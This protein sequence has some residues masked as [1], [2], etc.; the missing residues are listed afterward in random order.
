LKEKSMLKIYGIPNCDTVQKAIKW[1][2]TH[3]MEYEFHDFKKDGIT[4]R[5][6]ESW[7]KKVPVEK[8]M[9]KAST[10][11]KELPTDQKPTTPEAMI[12]LMTSQPTSIKRPVLE[13]G[14]KVLVGFDLAAYEKL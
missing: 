7:L 10:P 11:Y 14:T 6:I 2:K 3:E 1:L 9:N 4:K 13:K 5:K 12:A 8:L